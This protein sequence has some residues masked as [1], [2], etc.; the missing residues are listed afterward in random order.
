MC[1]TES[2]VGRLVTQEDKKDKLIARYE[3]YEKSQSELQDRWVISTS[4]AALGITLTLVGNFR[5]QL[6]SHAWL[7]IIAW[8]LFATGV[9]GGLVSIAT[10]RAATRK[11]TKHMQDRPDEPPTQAVMEPWNSVTEILNYLALAALC[12]GLIL[13]VVF[14]SV[15]VCNIG[16]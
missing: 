3:E 14:A 7:I 12:L 9:I 4:G 8:T 2:A 5:E 16:R 6:Q 1:L 13:V 15:A 11:L 10:G